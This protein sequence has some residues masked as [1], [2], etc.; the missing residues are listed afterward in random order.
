MS[1]NDYQKIMDAHNGM[2]KFCNKCGNRA[3][4]DESVFCTKCGTQY[5]QNI[6][7]KKDLVCP[8]CG[9]EIF[10]KQSVFCAR[11]GSPILPNQPPTDQLPSKPVPILKSAESS[12]Y[13]AIGIT[14]PACP[15]CNFQFDKMPKSK[16]QCPNCKKTIYNR[17]RPL[18]NKKV[19]LT[20]DQLVILEDELK[21]RRTLSMINRYIT[22]PRQQTVYDNIK[23]ELTPKFGKNPKDS[24]IFWAFLNKETRYYA[25]QNNWGLYSNVIRQQAELLQNE[26]KNK[27]ALTFYLWVCYLDINGS[28]NIGGLEKL[29]GV[30]PFNPKMGFLAPGIIDQI[31]K[32]NESLGLSQ[33]DIK[34]LFLEHNTKI[35]DSLKLPI[36]P[37]RAWIDIEKA[38]RQEK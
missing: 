10:D 38:I 28:E 27:Q 31:V 3:I 24:D 2:S 17:T 25:S 12:R 29:L 5:I 13:T 16:R 14:T 20:E 37:D 6:P 11:C 21:I 22:T 8:N 32:I 33:D 15:Y 18:D 34:T 36:S 26:D 19:L 1:I 4:N 7:E 35:H 9:I 23:L 30:R